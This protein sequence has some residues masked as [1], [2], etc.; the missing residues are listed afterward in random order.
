MPTRDLA[1][2]IQGC[3]E[4]RAWVWD[5]AMEDAR[6]DFGLY[7]RDELLKFISAGGLENLTFREQRSLEGNPSAVVDSYNFHA[8]TKYG[9]LAFYYA[10]A[11]N[12][13][14]IK[15]FKLNTEPDPRTLPSAN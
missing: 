11:T 13:W 4:G 3:G 7:T 5:V 15:S 1:A 2:F 10:R 8:G 14:I 12:K 6:S 9:Y